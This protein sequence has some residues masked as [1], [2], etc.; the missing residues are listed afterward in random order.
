MLTLSPIL[1]IRHPAITIPSVYRALTDVGG[2]S[3]IDIYT[4][5]F[6]HNQSFTA[7]RALFDWFCS[8]KYP[9][10]KTVPRGNASFPL[11]IDGVDLVDDNERVVAAI[12]E[13]VGLDKGGVAMAWDP[14][15][16]EVR[17]KQPSG[18]QRFLSTLQASSGPTKTAWRGGKVDVEVEYAKWVSEFGEK[19]A[20]RFRE[21]VEATVG[22]YEY[23]WQYR[24]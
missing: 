2:S 20:G 7:S 12:C 15:S 6:M 3:V 4:P 17:A 23:L 22:D 5:F 1:T 13:R 10:R 9:S 24:I 21:V 11:V 18:V 16:A 8:Q 19:V 14:V